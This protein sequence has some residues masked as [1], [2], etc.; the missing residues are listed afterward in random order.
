MQYP[1]A[2]RTRTVLLHSSVHDDEPC[3]CGSCCELRA[4]IRRNAELIPGRCTE[5]SPL[6]G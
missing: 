5:V 2:Q 6:P 3:L 1:G 4:L